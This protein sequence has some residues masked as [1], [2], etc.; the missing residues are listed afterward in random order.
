MKKLLI[1]FAAIILALQ[2]FALASATTP[3]TDI[4][5]NTNIIK[6]KNTALLGATTHKVIAEA[7]ETRV[8]LLESISMSPSAIKTSTFNLAYQIYYTSN[9]LK[10]AE[11]A[12][13]WLFASNE[14]ISKYNSSCGYST[15]S[16]EQAVKDMENMLNLLF[17][18]LFV[19]IAMQQTSAIYEGLELYKTLD[20][21]YKLISDCGSDATKAKLQELY[22]REFAEWF[23]IERCIIPYLIQNYHIPVMTASGMYGTMSWAFTSSIRQS[24]LTNRQDLL[25]AERTILNGGY[26]TIAKKE[27]NKDCSRSNYFK[28]I[29]F[30]KTLT[31]ESLSK[32]I[33]IE[34]GFFANAL[35]HI[36][37]SE[38]SHKMIEYEAS[39]TDWVKIR[40]EITL[41]L[42]SASQARYNQATMQLFTYM[43]DSL[44]RV[45]KGENYE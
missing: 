20:A 31:K 32:A 9:M 28:A 25:K 33:T 16:N 44:I 24:S 30:L 38:I 7:N 18:N 37:Y 5:G 8:F 41:L 34:E 19:N 12:W 35:D 39:L 13:A 15:N 14:L 17:D 23:K 10:T 22:C 42:P 4:F 29:D 1:R 27:I 6:L 11:D 3:A 26:A 45:Q 40:E 36:K 43:Y 21:Y 2:C